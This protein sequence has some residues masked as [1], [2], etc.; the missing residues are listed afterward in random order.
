MSRGDIARLT[1]TVDAEALVECVAEALWQAPNIRCMGRSR[2]TDWAGESNN[3]KDTHRSDADA[4][5]RAA[6]RA[7]GLTCSDR[8]FLIDV[9]TE[10]EEFERKR[11][12]EAGAAAC[13]K[14]RSLLLAL[15]R[16]VEGRPTQVVL[17]PFLDVMRD[18][19]GGR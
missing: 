2:L 5:L 8:W 6:V 16:V 4:A 13:A 18:A 17:D 14:L 9:L 1:Q 7:S 3:T 19:K 15:H 12:A 11:K 10:R